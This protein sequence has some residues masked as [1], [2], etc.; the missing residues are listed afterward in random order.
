MVRLGTR[1]WR[2]NQVAPSGTCGRGDG[3]RRVPTASSRKNNLVYL[4]GPLWPKPRIDQTADPIFIRPIRR[5]LENPSVAQHRP[6]GAG[7]DVHAKGI[8]LVRHKFLLSLAAGRRQADLS[9][10]ALSWTLPRPR[11]Q[12]TGTELLSGS[13]AVSWWDI[14]WTPFRG[15]S[16]PVGEGRTSGPDIVRWPRL[17]GQLGSF[18]TSAM[19]RFP[20]NT[21]WRPYRH[22]ALTDIV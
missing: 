14:D 3:R 5:T 6:A 13:P 16:R 21:I 11:P 12:E 19:G 18:G 1:L 15:R 8:D 2:T 10:L 4:R 20:P 9:P 22:T 17:F 7:R